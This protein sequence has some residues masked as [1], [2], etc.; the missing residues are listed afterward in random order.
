MLLLGLSLELLC[1]HGRVGAAYAC[2]N[3]PPQK[4]LCCWPL[5]RFRANMPMENVV[6]ERTRCPLCICCV[7]DDLRACLWRS[8]SIGNLDP[9]A[10]A[11][12]M[13]AT[14]SKVPKTNAQHNITTETLLI[15]YVFR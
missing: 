10:N 13:G 15:V 2:V 4:V 6:W 3:F 1:V 8:Y 7:C 5:P 12:Y 9:S 14:P 11:V